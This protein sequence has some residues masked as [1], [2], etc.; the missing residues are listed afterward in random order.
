MLVFHPGYVDAQLVRTS[1]VTLARTIDVE[2]LG[3]SDLRDFV[4]DHG[5]ELIT[6]CDL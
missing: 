2:T 6:Y 5:F 4:R 3:G 1:S